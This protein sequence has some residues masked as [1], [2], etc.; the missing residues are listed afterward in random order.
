MRKITLVEAFREA[1]C[2]QMQKNPDVFIMGEDSRIGG[3]FLFTLGIAGRFGDERVIDTPISETGFIGAG[4]GAAMRGMRPIIDL[5][6][7]DF[8]FCAMEQI[9]HNAAKLRYASNGQVSIPCVLHFPTGASGRGCTHAQSMETYFMHIPG[10]KVIV[11]STPYD[12]KG[13]LHAAIEDENF[14]IICSHK[15]LYGSKGRRADM[16]EG[17]DKS[18]PETYYK[19]PLGKADVKQAGCDITVVSTLLMLHRCVDAAVE[20]EQE[21]VSV[22]VIDLR[23]LVPLDHE[24]ILQ[25]VKKTGRLLIV[26]EDSVSYGWGAE[27]AACVA[28][29]GFSYLRCPVVRLACADVPM[30]AAPKLE[31]FV[32]PDKEKI[33][34][35]ILQMVRA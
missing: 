18:V 28:Q 20:L 16:F 7:G 10:L 33:K 26:E 12:A 2:E 4:I 34:E 3:S 21:G 24:T 5:Q 30:P 31:A 1:I 17:I 19:I 13:L 25:S 6:Y 32:V 9:A 8:A 15:H 22:E 14:C 23:T 27:V 35:K 29:E 11:P